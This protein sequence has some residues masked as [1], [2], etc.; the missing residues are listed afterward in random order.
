MIASSSNGS[1]GSNIQAEAASLRPESLMNARRNPR[2]TSRS[3]RDQFSTGSPVRRGG[4]GRNDVAE[5]DRVT[6]H[7]MIEIAH[8]QR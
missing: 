2:S 1:I 6:Y 3:A 4:V 7:R 8:K 5:R